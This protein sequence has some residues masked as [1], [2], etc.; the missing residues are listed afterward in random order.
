MVEFWQQFVIT[1]GAA[2]LFPA[3]ACS[4]SKLIGLQQQLAG[5]ILASCEISFVFPLSSSAVLSA[6]FLCSSLFLRPVVPA[7]LGRND[8]SVAA[9]CLCVWHRDVSPPALTP[10]L[11]PNHRRSP[12]PTA[13]FPLHLFC[14]CP[15]LSE[16]WRC[17][18]PPLPQQWGRQR[19]TETHRRQQTATELH[20]L[21]I[22]FHWGHFWNSPS[23]LLAKW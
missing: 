1:N 17:P 2:S 9:V 19:N 16:R 4:S 20:D 14:L 18:P 11:S 6:L 3:S 12:N 22:D 8:E 5:Q 13:S 23:D 10:S 15:S 21:P 7:D